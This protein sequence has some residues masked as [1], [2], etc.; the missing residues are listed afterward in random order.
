[1]VSPGATV[2]TGGGTVAETDAAL[3]TANI[4]VPTAHANN[5]RLRITDQ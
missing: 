1:M 3:P 4:N 2:S 5:N